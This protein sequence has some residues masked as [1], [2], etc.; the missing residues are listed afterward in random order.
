MGW[1][2]TLPHE[3]HGALKSHIILRNPEDHVRHRALRS[4]IAATLSIPGDGE[5]VSNSGRHTMSNSQIPSDVLNFTYDLSTTTSTVM[6]DR[7]VT[8]TSLCTSILTSKAQYQEG[9]N[10]SDNLFVLFNRLIL[11]C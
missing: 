11:V 3:R 4:I 2:A 9:K 1:N 10:G 7:L 8:L 6:N 5:W